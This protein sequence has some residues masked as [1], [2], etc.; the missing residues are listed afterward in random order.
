MRNK[1]GKIV[2]RHLAQ[3]SQGESC[4]TTLHDAA[5]VAARQIASATLR[6]KFRHNRTAERL[7]HLTH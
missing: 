2:V 4:E 3:N 5:W 1:N 7:S 6:Q